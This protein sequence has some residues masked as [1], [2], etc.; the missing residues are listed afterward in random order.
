MGHRK[1]QGII[2]KT[3]NFDTLQVTRNAWCKGRQNALGASCI[4][5]EM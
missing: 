4:Q 2:F 3:I 1:P 5:G